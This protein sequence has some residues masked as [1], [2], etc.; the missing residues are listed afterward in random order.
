LRSH[1]QSADMQWDFRSEWHID[2]LVASIHYDA[3]ALHN[4]RTTPHELARAKLWP[5][6]RRLAPGL[7]MKLWGAVAGILPDCGEHWRVWIDWYEHILEGSPPMMRMRPPQNGQACSGAFG[8]SGLALAALTAS[9]GMSGT[10][11]NARRRAIFLARVWQVRRGAL[12]AIG[13]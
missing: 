13:G 10:T 9:I 1:I 12:F 7:V 8:P 4:Q 2:D 6:D 11:G 3:V 5:L